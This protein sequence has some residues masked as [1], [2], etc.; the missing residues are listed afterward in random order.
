MTPCHTCPLY[1]ESHARTGLPAK[2]A[3]CGAVYGRRRRKRRYSVERELAPYP[4]L[5]EVYERHVR[6]ARERAKEEDER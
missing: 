3:R 1:S 4:G 6:A 5:R 2:C